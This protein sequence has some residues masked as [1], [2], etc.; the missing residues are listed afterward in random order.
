MAKV[1]NGSFLK[2][3][4]ENGNLDELDEAEEEVAR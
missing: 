4:I 1:E 2:K 3:Q